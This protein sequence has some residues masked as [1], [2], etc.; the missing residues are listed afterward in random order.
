MNFIVEKIIFDYFKGFRHF[1]A[2]LPFAGVIVGKNGLG[3]TSMWDGHLWLWTDKDS[4]LH[5]NP[6]IRPDYAEE[7]EPSVTEVIN[8]DGK[9]LTVRKYQSDG[10]NKKQKESHGGFTPVWHIMP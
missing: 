10:R 2:E 5:S 4:L 1:E 8:I 3:K 6:N 9:R 7:S